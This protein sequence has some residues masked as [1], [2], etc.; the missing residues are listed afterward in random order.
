MH[1][2]TQMEMENRLVANELDDGKEVSVEWHE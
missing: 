1:E 2:T